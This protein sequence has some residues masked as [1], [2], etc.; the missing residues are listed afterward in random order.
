VIVIC[1]PDGAITAASSGVR[2]AKLTPN[3]ARN[4]HPGNLLRIPFGESSDHPSIVI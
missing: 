1:S 3:R 2:A 4:F